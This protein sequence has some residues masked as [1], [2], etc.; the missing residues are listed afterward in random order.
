VITTST[1]TA[2]K[3]VAEFGVDRGRIV[4]IEPGTDA[5][6]R[7]TGSAGGPCHILAVGTL[8]PRKG[9]DVLL[10]ALAGLTDLDW[11]LTIA[12]SAER[13]PAHAA[14]LAALA[15]AL[16][17]DGRVRFAGEVDATA[18]DALWQEADLFALATWFEGFGMAVAEALKRGLPVA[19]CAGG[20]ASHLVTPEC[21]VVCAPGDHVQ[22]GKALRRL[23]F[24]RDLR[25]AMA[26]AA[27]ALGL[28]LPG[29]DTQ[30][31]AFEEALS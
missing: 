15:R 12:G 23:V 21:G 22:L 9:H 27:W 29:W 31:Q 5:A 24:D 19:V 1:G 7:S 13:A 25:R 26:D 11:R 2:D 14:Q 20:A 17:I 4:V 28:S 8:V 10:R 30:I 16:G 3:L 6:P 18:L